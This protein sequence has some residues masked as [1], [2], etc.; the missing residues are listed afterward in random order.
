MGRV[1]V[2]GSINVDL[3]CRAERHPRPGETLPGS[4]FATHPGGKGANQAVAAAR[5]GA[6]TH[7]LGRVGDD[8]FGREQ[9]EFLSNQGIRTDGVRRTEGVATGV[10]LIVVDEMGENSIVVVPGANGR[11]VVEDI[12]V[13]FAPGDVVVCQFEVPLEVVRGAFESARAAGATT[14]LNPAPA[15]SCSPELLAMADILVVNES[16]LSFFSRTEEAD[17]A[18]AADVAQSLRALRTAPGQVVVATLGA[19]GLVALVGDEAIGLS[20]HAVKAVDTTGAGDTFVGALAAR[21][22]AGASSREA[23][24]YANTAASICVERAGAGPSIPTAREVESRITG[25]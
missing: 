24:D 9:V 14:V 6:D 8:G 10:A 19:H 1:L 15:S 7:M 4:D 2:V 25:R 18:N 11:V 20:G 17:P 23:L 12:D 5:S 13:A 16:E 21:I 22:A 3:V